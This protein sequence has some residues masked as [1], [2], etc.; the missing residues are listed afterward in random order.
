M[1]SDVATCFHWLFLGFDSLG[2]SSSH[3]SDESHFS[4]PPICEANSVFPFSSNLAVM[5]SKLF[6]NDNTL[7]QQQQHQQQLQQQ[8][9]S[10]GLADLSKSL[11]TGSM[12]HLIRL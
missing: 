12:F 6:S 4:S 10:S 8:H 9:F 3:L 5:H 1:K 11:A 7:Q 2:L